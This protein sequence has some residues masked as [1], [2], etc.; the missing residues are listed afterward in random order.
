MYCLA[1]PFESCI[2]LVYIVDS[3]I[4]GDCI[5]GYILLNILSDKICFLSVLKTFSTP[6]LPASMLSFLCTNLFAPM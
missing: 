2:F 5:V 1:E 3:F 6:V 4:Q